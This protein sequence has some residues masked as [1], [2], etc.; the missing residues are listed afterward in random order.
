M[1]LARVV[2]K[3]LKPYAVSLDLELELESIVYNHGKDDVLSHAHNC[4]GKKTVNR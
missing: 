3:T 1:S 2:G 4:S